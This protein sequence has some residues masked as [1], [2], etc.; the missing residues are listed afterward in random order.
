MQKFETLRQPLLWELAMSPEE[1]EEKK[2]PVTFMRTLGPML[3][4]QVK[5]E[6]DYLS[7]Q[8]FNKW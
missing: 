1:E 4:I 8:Q 6:N 3:L 7:I 2:M 5:D